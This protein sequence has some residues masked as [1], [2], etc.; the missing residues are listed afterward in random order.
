M[1]SQVT[2]LATRRAFS[3]TSKQCGAHFKEGVYSNIPVKIHNRKI[4][5]AFIH[6]G[7]FALGFAVPF[8]SSY[9]QLK[10]FGAF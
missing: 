7:F 3:A 10:K 6:F 8:I 9:V 5:Y 4:P 2:R 1:F